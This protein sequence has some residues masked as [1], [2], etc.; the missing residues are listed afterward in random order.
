M[1]IQGYHIPD[2][3]LYTKEHEWAREEG[4]IVRVG[5]TD[6]AAK[7]LNDVVYVTPPKVNDKVEQ[8]KPM[9]TVE[10]IKAVS[11]VYSP[12]SGTVARANGQLDSHPELVNKS[13]Y[14]DGWLIEVKPSNFASEKKTLLDAEAYT[15]YLSTLLKK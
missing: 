4:P 14:G 5:V 7:T 9:G 1:D 12:I 11:E 10:S 13:P 2:E 3:L 8:L 6:Y 15:A